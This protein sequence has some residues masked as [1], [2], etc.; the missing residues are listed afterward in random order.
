MRGHDL[1]K[2]LMSTLNPL[3]SLN[4]VGALLKEK[5]RNELIKFQTFS[6]PDLISRDFVSIFGQIIAKAQKE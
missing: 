4:Q 1:E 2:L 6:Y 5:Q 3:G